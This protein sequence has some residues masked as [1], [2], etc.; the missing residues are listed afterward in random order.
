MSNITVPLSP[1]SNH[2][3]CDHPT[4]IFGINYIGS[5]PPYVQYKQN[6]EHITLYNPNP[7]TLGPQQTQ[8]IYFPIQVATSL[9]GYSIIYGSDLLFRHGLQSDLTIQ[10]T[11]DF[12]L[13]TKIYNKT[14]H[15]CEF[16][17][18]GLTFH[19]ITIAPIIHKYL[20]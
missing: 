17:P 11:N 2:H 14:T 6:C 4:P 3:S 13:S 9:M 12:F 10:S 8:T 16:P 7:I 19:C 1:T 5:P 15:N 18:F 20:L